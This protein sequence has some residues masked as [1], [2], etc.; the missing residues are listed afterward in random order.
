M[1]PYAVSF[2]GRHLTRLQN[3]LARYRNNPKDVTFDELKTLLEAYG[4]EVKNHSGGSHYSV[5]H[6]KYSVIPPMEPNTI[7]M[8]KPAV[9][10]VYVR[11][12]LKWIEK[13]IGQQE[14]EG[15]CEKI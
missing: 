5:S 6:P 15:D 14:A 2:R 8:K 12:S 3:K 13:V 7:P 11:R 1:T 9:L 10:E 4:F